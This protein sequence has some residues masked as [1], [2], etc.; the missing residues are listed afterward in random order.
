MKTKTQK[1]EMT[2]LVECMAKLIEEGYT[3]NFLIK[4]N[5]LV[6]ENGTK[7]TPEQVRIVNFYRFEG[8]SDP[9]DNCILYAIETSDKK[10]GAISD[11]YGPYSDSKITAFITQVEEIS[12]KEHEVQN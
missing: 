8:E 6:A 5:F 7:Y 1:T 10:K 3:E 9:A 11:A 12:K 2:T 4:G